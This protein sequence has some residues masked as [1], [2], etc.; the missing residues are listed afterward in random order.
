MPFTNRNANRNTPMCEE[1]DTEVING[2][3]CDCGTYEPC[4]DKAADHLERSTGYRPK[5]R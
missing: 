5:G 1:C 3:G 2:L 4:A